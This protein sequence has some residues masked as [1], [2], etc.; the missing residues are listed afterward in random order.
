MKILGLNMESLRFQTLLWDKQWLVKA[1]DEHNQ[2]D[3]LF[4]TKC[5][6]KENVWSLIIDSVSYAN[7]DGTTMVDFLKL[8]ITKHAT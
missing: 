8:P 6:I 2:R 7:V 1:I 4:H 5:L 3:N